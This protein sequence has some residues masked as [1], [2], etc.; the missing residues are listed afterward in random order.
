MEVIIN[1]EAVLEQTF[2]AL[3][4]LFMILIVTVNDV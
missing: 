2:D 1:F 3:M 4:S